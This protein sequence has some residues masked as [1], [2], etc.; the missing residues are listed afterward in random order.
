[1]KKRVITIAAV[2]AVLCAIAG[3]AW[4]WL[5]PKWPDFP[6][7]TNNVPQVVVQVDRDY[8]YH[9]GDLITVELFVKEAKGTTVDPN[10]VTVGGDFELNSK[11]VAAQKKL[12][13]GSVVHRIRLKVQTFKVKPEAVL[14]STI[15]YKEGDKRLDIT[16]PAQSLFW[17]NTYD[18]RDKIK[19]GDN[20]RVPNWLLFARYVTPL[21]LGSIAFLVLCAVAVRNWFRNRPKFVP[22]QQRLRV[23]ELLGLVTSGTASK[24]DHL[25]LDRL[26]RDHFNVGPVPASQLNNS[27]V[28][29][30]EFLKLNAPA[31][32]AREA[33]DEGG[34]A[35][36]AKLGGNLLS[37]WR[38][39]QVVAP[40]AD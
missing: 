30:V 3:G 31:I 11:P 25:E 14:N 35:Q 38:E 5:T 36:L 18:G 19:E 12:D 34:R 9:I 13:D 40:A 15:G 10:S 33:L 37:I 22:D 29:L 32:Y 39:G 26:V 23:D 2:A 21:S 4:W 1:M 6:A 16:V 24:E 27:D 8:A 17:S 7:A 20:P 28:V